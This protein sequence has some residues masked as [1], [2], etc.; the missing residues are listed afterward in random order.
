MNEADTR[1]ELIDPK[2]KQA[3]WGD[4][5]ESR[6][7]REYNI[8]AGE[9]RAG[10]IRASQMKADYVL[11]YKNRKLAVVEAKS[12]E[13]EVG[14]GVAQAKQYATKLELDY[15]YATNG[16]SIYEICLTNGVEQLVD[17]FP[18]PA[19]LWNKTFGDSN[20]WQSKFN[21]VPFEDVNG[22]KQARY[23][24]E[25]AVNR[26]MEAVAN[27]KQRILLTLATGTGKTFVAF[28]VAWKL[29][30]SRWNLRKDAKR[31]PRILFL[32]DRNILANQ[33]YLDFGAF[34]EDA[35]VRINPAQI[36][37][38]GEV[39]KNGSVFFTI[40]QTFM[41]GAEGKPYFGDYEPD[42]FDFVVIDEC[43][44]GGAN[45]ESNWR[46]ILNYFSPAV[47]LGLTATP[48]RIDN[49][50][51]Y[52]YFGEPVYKYSLKEGIQD[53]FLTPFKVKRI[54][55]TL[56]EYV[57]TP[58]DEVLEG[59]VEEGYVYTEKDFN[60][61]IVIPERERKRVQEMLANI[62]QQ[63]KTLVFCAN[64]AHAAMVRDIVNQE[65]KVKKTDYCVR[66]TANDGAIGD[67]YLK[68][69]QDNDKTIPTIITTSQKLTTGVDARNVRNV[70]LLRP[71]NS[72][73]E[74]KQIIG[75]GTRLFEGKHYFTI[76]DFVNAYHLFSDAEWDGEP[77][78]PEPKVPKK[79]KEEGEEGT[80]GGE[81]DGEGDD[82]EPSAK[83]I[84]IK[85]SDGKA[86]EIQS[87]R[88]TMFYVDGKPISAEEFLQRLFN[89]L[90]LPEFFGT[91]D[92]LRK[93]W[94]NPITRSE[95]LKKLEQQGCGKDDLVKLQEM[96]DADNCDLF[97]VLEYISYA[98]KPI[99]RSERVEQAQSNIYTFL[100]EKQRDFI[101]FI[102]RNYVQDGVDELDMS[103]L[104]AT[105]TSKYGSV[106]EGQKALGGV[107]EI[108][109]V[110]VDFQQHLYNEK[111]A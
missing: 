30:Q 111:V 54:Q 95:L 94:A 88:S 42:F 107:E 65:V 43:H 4:V 25:I 23:Y 41:S 93:L 66:V 109:R 10:G 92:T 1:A 76:V 46:D 48:K 27:N 100:N 11:V 80:D 49:V 20:E 24:Q 63:E 21:A 40:F 73:I 105:L 22:T 86:R 44:R 39:P 69:F 106:Y 19:E 83:K 7:Q 85:L 9:I 15:T 71:V 34:K 56:D 62:N 35:L 31:T 58:D 45:D 98:R 28:Q 3:G 36:A 38:R 110:F 5:A 79:P 82:T 74:F 33:A 59:E 78:E 13:L 57:Y 67:T 29:F 2:L 52:K 72:M 47:H 90:K 14:E 84:K 102:L 89:T 104:S 87:M 51:T 6:V 53:G 55:T 108:K 75:R 99:T 97:D 50:D 91:E 61:K 68:Q 12:D 37:K 16:K 60:K 18:T 70:V 8:N 81:G 103:K 96:I 17:S 32:A 101:G 26:V 77:I 64:Q